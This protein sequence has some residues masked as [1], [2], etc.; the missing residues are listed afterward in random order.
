MYG[1]DTIKDYY[2]IHFNFTKGVEKYFVYRYMRNRK[3]ST[4]QMWLLAENKQ[5]N[6]ELISEG[7]A[8]DIGEEQKI[9][10]RFNLPAKRCTRLI[11]FNT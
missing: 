9:I 11:T 6:P 3:L 5:Y 4:E 2:V 8:I 7:E 10:N 1:I